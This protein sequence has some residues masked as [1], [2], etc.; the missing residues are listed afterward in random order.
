[1]QHRRSTGDKED[2]LGATLSL[3]C[4]SM[5]PD[6]VEEDMKAILVCYDHENVGLWTLSVSPKRAQEEVVKWIVDKL[7]E[8]GYSGVSM[9]LSLQC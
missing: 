8:C 5:T 3:D 7:D 9:T 1:M 4:S 2:H 6:E